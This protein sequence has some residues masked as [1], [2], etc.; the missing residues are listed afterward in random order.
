MFYS[1]TLDCWLMFR[2]F[3]WSVT[4]DLLKCSFSVLLTCNF[5]SKIV[6]RNVLLFIFNGTHWPYAHHN[7]SKKNKEKKNESFYKLFIS[8]IFL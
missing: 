7:D 2:T 5:D 8:V 3:P 6:C 4:L 1:G